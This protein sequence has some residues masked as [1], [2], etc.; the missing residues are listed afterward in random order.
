MFINQSIQLG[1]GCRNG[2]VIFLFLFSCST[3]LLISPRWVATMG[4]GGDCRAESFIYNHLQH[5]HRL[6][7]RLTAI[8]CQNIQ[9]AK[10]IKPH[11]S[12]WPL[13]LSLSLSVSLSPSFSLSIYLSLSNSNSNSFIGTITT[14]HSI[15][16]AQCSLFLILKKVWFNM[17]PKKGKQCFK[18]DHKWR[19]MTV[20]RTLNTKL[21]VFTGCCGVT[22]GL[23]CQTNSEKCV[24]DKETGFTKMKR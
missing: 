2:C 4:G 19:I 8:V 18:S 21:N 1:N 15:A 9:T 13:S 20:Y 16:K 5:K 23:Q 17:N 14:K 24:C 10:S 3:L 12:N 22:I 7:E 11:A 6:I